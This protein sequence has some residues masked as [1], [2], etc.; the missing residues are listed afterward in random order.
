MYSNNL[1]NIYSIFAH[2]NSSNCTWF[3]RFDLASGWLGSLSFFH[4]FFGFWLSVAFGTKLSHALPP[5]RC[6]VL[7][8]H[9]CETEIIKWIIF[10]LI[11]A[12]SDSRNERLCAISCVC[13]VRRRRRWRWLALTPT[14]SW[15]GFRVA[16]HLPNFI[17]NVTGNFVVGNSFSNYLLAGQ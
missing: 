8:R 11:L 3:M 5:L 16:P 13:P 4:F 1:K 6:T 2:P 10:V 17:G 9:H 7:F 15:V 14:G 12:S